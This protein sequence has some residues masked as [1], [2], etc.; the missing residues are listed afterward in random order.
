MK[1]KE[2]KNQDFNFFSFATSKHDVPQFSEGGRKEWIDYGDKN[3]YPDF[4]IEL[5]N[6]SSKHNSLLKKKVNMSAGNGFIITEENKEIIK[7]ENGSENLNDI[8]FKNAYDLMVYGCYSL[9]IT[10]SNDRKSISRISYIDSSKIRIAKELE[11]DSEM[12]KRQADGVDFY[13][14]SPDWA[15][16]RKAKNKPEIV[17]GYS[18]K[19]NDAST[20]IIYVKEYRPGTSYYV[21]PDYIS[22]VQWIQLDEQIANFHLS[23][24]HNGFTPS[25]VISFKGGTPSEEERDALYRNIQDK[26][27]GTSNGSKVFITF[28]DNKDKAPEFIPIELSSSDERFLNLEGQIQQNII[29]AHNATP[30][31]AGVGIAGK[32][33]TSAEVIENEKMF[34]SNV[35]DQ[36]QRLLERTFNMIQEVNKSGVILK[37]DGVKSFDK[38][39]IEEIKSQTIDDTIGNFI[40]EKIERIKIETELNK[41]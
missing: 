34:K 31:V 40:E 3:L 12:A 5:M 24:V 20:Q 22:S 8:A 28:S 7:N 32:L 21:L 41:N 38:E 36:K 37:L 33:G 6:S 35:I 30:I 19:Y 11:D 4:L 13:Y 39:D 9:S 27:A 16:T 25:M 29:I 18:E 26:Y 14:V 2:N 23:S 10:W 1:N 17:Q 15:N